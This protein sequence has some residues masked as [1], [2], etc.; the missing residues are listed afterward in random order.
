MNY[1]KHAPGPRGQC[2]PR[3]LQEDALAL[4]GELDLSLVATDEH[5]GPLPFAPPRAS[6]RRRLR[7]LHAAQDRRSDSIWVART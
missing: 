7:L 5:L 2:W 1:L 3:H 4:F 6:S